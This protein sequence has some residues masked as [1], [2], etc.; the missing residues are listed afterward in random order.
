MV[1]AFHAP[2]ERLENKMFKGLGNLASMLKN[3]QQI[4]G[5][6][7]QMTEELKHQRVTGTAGAGMVEVELTGAMEMLRC[8][9]DPQLFAQ[10]DR[11]MIEDLV[12]AA[13]NQAIEK[14]KQLH[15]EAMQNLTGGISLPDGVQEMLG[16]LGEE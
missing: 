4:T 7:G 16:K 11:E 15:I 13:V 3:A 10:G 6:M 14:S 1:G 5:Q 2:Y 9:I 12:V 8:K